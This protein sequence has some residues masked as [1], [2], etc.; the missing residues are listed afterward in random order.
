MIKQSKFTQLINPIK[1]HKLKFIMIK[2]Y[3]YYKIAL[4]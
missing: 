1:K 2:N 3:K 4:T